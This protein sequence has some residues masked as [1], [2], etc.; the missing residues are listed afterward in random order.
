MGEINYEFAAD[1]DIVSPWRERLT[2]HTSEISLSTPHSGALSD[3][4]RG[5]R[6]APGDKMRNGFH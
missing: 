6:Y 2:T 1:I 3:G 5:G 4:T